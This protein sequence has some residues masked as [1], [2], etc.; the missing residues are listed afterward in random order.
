[1]G[2]YISNLNDMSAAISVRKYPSHNH[3]NNETSN[4][5]LVCN[6]KPWWVD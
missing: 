5:C 1:M 6:P 4:T 3:K 2:L